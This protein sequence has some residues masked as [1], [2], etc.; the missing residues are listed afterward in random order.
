MSARAKFHVEHNVKPETVT[1]ILPIFDG[2]NNITYQEV[3]NNLPKGLWEHSEE[4]VKRKYLNQNLYILTLFHFISK[5]NKKQVYTLNPLGKKM[6]K[7][8]YYNKKLFFDIMHYY[9]YSSWIKEFKKTKYL[10]SWTYRQICDILWRQENGY[11]NNKKII[12]EVYNLAITEF[13]NNSIS[14]SIHAVRGVRNWLMALQPPFIKKEGGKAVRANERD[15]SSIEL[16][17]LAIDMYY[18]EHN[19]RYGTPILMDESKEEYL[20]KVCLINKKN[21]RNLIDLCVKMFGNLLKWHSSTWGRS[22][23]LSRKV[24]IIEM[25]EMT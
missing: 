19:I 14:L 21:I 11:I 7:I 2:D 18:L 10:F 25:E 8:L 5:D 22:L 15:H 23:I 13:N 17:F 3:F 16:I 9:Y 1:K 6:L 12:G 4:E 20:A 24:E